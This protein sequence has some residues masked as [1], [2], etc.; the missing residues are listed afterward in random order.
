MKNNIKTRRSPYK[1]FLLL[2][3]LIGTICLTYIYLKNKTVD[4]N[5]ISKYRIEEVNYFKDYLYNKNVYKSAVCVDSFNTLYR[6]LITYKLSDT[7]LVFV[8][9]YREA[10][11][12]YIAK[13]SIGIY[14]SYFENKF[15]WLIPEVSY[16]L[17][18]DAQN[19]IDSAISI[20]SKELDVIYLYRLHGYYVQLLAFNKDVNE[21]YILDYNRNQWSTSSFSYVAAI[22]NTYINFGD[23]KFI[24]SKQFNIDSL[25][26][27]MP[28]Y[29]EL[30]KMAPR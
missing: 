9:F 30:I 1:N 27:I 21:F 8:S 19:N 11:L 10:F 4:K 20:V 22:P 17:D 24:N 16:L 15:D 13:D 29:S 26:Y 12:L 25:K 14:K 6:S 3:C 23:I 2:F 18:Q 5:Y 28:D 7:N